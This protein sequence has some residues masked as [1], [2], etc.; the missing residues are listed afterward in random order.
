L[1]KFLRRFFRFISGNR[2][3]LRFLRNRFDFGFIEVSQASDA[4]SSPIRTKSVAAIFTSP[5]FIGSCHPKGSD[6]PG[7]GFGIILRLLDDTLVIKSILLVADGMSLP[8][9][10]FCPASHLIVLRAASQSWVFGYYLSDETAGRSQE[11][12]GGH[13]QYRLLN[14]PQK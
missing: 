4:V 12:A 8:D 9:V 1:I 5:V 7:H 10:P 11:P 6:K 13:S 3:T 14:G 2:P